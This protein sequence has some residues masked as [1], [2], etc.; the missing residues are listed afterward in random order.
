MDR[1]L[2]KTGTNMLAGSNEFI[3]ALRK[4][5]LLP[6]FAETVE[7]LRHIRLVAAYSGDFNGIS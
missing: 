6:Y 3:A 1:S 4:L 2:L 5:L 7:S